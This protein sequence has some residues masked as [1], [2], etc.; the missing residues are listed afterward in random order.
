VTS[1][2]LLDGDTHT[3]VAVTAVNSNN[4]AVMTTRGDVKAQT[5][6]LRP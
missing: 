4:V 5:K 2:N 3:V 1:I 6:T